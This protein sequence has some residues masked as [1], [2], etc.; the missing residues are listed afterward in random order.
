MKNDKLNEMY[1]R[2]AEEL[3]ISS[4]VFDDA[5]TSYKAVG[6]YL[7]NNL[8]YEVD[9]YPQGS[10]ALGTTVKP[11]NDD[12]DY[13]LDMV[14]I[15]DE[16]IKDPKTLKNIV[17]DSLKES[18]RYHSMLDDEKKRC[19]RINY[20][21][22]KFHLDIVPANTLQGTNLRITNKDE[23]GIYT[24]TESNPKG[25][26]DWFQNK[27]LNEK[28]NIIKKYREKYSNNIEP[29]D[30]TK[31]HTNLQKSIML[32]KRHRDIMYLDKNISIENKP[33][34]IIITTIMAKLYDENNSVLD[35]LYKF[36]FK[37]ESCFEYDE[38]GN[39]IIKNPVNSKENFADKWITHPERKDAFYTWVKKVKVDLIESNFLNITGQI[40]QATYLK[41]IFGSSIIKKVYKE[42]TLDYKSSPSKYINHEGTPT[43]STT[44]TDIKIGG[45]TYYGY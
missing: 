16:N 1:S 15:L 23:K 17:G 28:Q 5:T 32:L 12:D 8:G 7:S 2:I 41:E 29:L 14:C 24:F 45:H 37:F 19:W 27:Q 20:K 43:L 25:Y 18:D 44:K 30:E 13:D 40:E 39:I 26:I 35:L 3:A 42:K 36:A 21:G 4:A 22:R 11:I 33:I 6:E 31:I 9:I 34:S 10:M 38:D